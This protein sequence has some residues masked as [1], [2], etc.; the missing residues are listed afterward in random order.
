M[1]ILAVDVDYQESTACVA[2]VIFNEWTKETPDKI[3][4]S[5]VE[6]IEPYVSGEFYK[7]ELPCI[8]KLLNDHEIKPDCI[9]VDGFVYLDGHSKP[10]LGKK[11]YDGLNSETIVIGVAK[12]SFNNISSDYE[13]YRGESK[14]PLYVTSAGIDTK[15]AKD[16]VASMHGEFRFP[17][18]LKIVDQ[19]CRNPES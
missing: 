17:A 16:F 18:L 15:K 13:V 1:I 11:L 6:N 5:R 9:V 2:G 3:I 19:T 8:F 10:G 12:R 4:T 14:N 7:R